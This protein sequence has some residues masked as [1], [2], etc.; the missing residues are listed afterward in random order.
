MNK[1]LL[2]GLHIL[3]FF[4]LSISMIESSL[5]FGQRMHI[6]LEELFRGYSLV[7]LNKE[8][9]GGAMLW[10]GFVMLYILYVYVRAGKA[11]GIDD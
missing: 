8:Y 3:M 5:R 11:L 6:I 1:I 4:Y 10:S 7:E 9:A 2:R